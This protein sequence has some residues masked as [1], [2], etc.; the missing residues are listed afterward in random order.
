MERADVDA[1]ACPDEQPAP[2][3]DAEA[4]VPPPPPPSL[5]ADDT[6]LESDMPALAPRT[7]TARRRARGYM[8]VTVST[9]LGNE[10]LLQMRGTDTLSHLRSKVR[11]R[12][13]LPNER[14]RLVLDG[15][16][17]NEAE[18]QIRASLLSSAQEG[19]GE[20][21]QG[22]QRRVLSRRGVTLD[23]VGV[24]DGAQILLSPAMTSGPLRR[25]DADEAANSS[26]S[27][28]GSSSS[29]GGIGGLGGGA[30][31]LS[32]NELNEDMLDALAARAATHPV[33]VMARVGDQLVQVKVTMMPED[34]ASLCSS[35][36]RALVAAAD[37][38]P[39][40]E[41]ASG[42]SDAPATAERDHQ[43]RSKV[44]GLLARMAMRRLLQMPDHLV[45]GK[46]SLACTEA[47]E[48]ALAGDAPPSAGAEPKDDD[49]ALA[50]PGDGEGSC[51]APQGR[52]RPRC[53]VCGKKLGL[54][55]SFE[56]R[57]K[58]LFCASHRYAD[59]HDCTFDYKG[60]GR[61]ALRDA[62]PEVI[63]PKVNHI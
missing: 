23:E 53:A 59:L 6:S 29:G 43:R 15:R 34:V 28:S 14:Q 36:P 32:M 7:K 3:V 25:T 27:S 11:R 22:A 35:G 47:P 1:N 41:D 50:E 37:G 10:L 31:V 56:C 54:A 8:H 61:R 63:A 55:C 58:R 40:G 12:T 57:C 16:D 49:E 52:R 46:R 2:A 4:V 42:L 13:G 39:S 9:A 26:S 33:S 24:R 17:L 18:L 48:E 44:E 19:S 62:L 21:V 30:V 51:T 20:P 45:P 38:D 60:A 5:E